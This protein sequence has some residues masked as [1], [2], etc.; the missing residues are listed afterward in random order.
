M[1]GF[2][3]YANLKDIKGNAIK[4][5]NNMIAHRGPDDAR[6]YSNS[7]VK[8]GFRRLSMLDLSHGGQPIYSQDRKKVLTFNGEIYNYKT[9]R[10][11]LKKKGYHFN[12][13]VDS[14]VIM[15]GYEAYGT[16]IFSKLNGMFAIALYDSTKHKVILARDYLGV[17]PLLYYQRGKD[18]MWASEIKAFLGNPAFKKE[19]NAK[20][21]PVHF[22]FDY[23][24]SR[25]TLFKNVYKVMPGQYIVHDFKTNQTKNHYFFRL[26][27]NH[28][29]NNMSV[30]HAVHTIRKLVRDSVQKH[31]VADVKGGSFLSSGIDSNYILSEASRKRPIHSFTLGYKNSKYSETKDASQ[32]AKRTHQQNTKIYMNADDFFSILPTVMYYEDSALSNAAQPQ[33]YILTKHA[34]N[35]VKFS[36][37]GEIPDEMCLGYQTQKDP[38]YFKKYKRAIPKWLRV[39]LKNIALRL[40]RFHGR[41]YLIRGGEPIWESYFRVNYLFDNYDRNKL[42]KGTD[43]KNFDAGKKY[44][45][46]VFDKVKDKDILTQE[47]YFETT[48]DLPM[49]MLEQADRMSMANSLELR[50][51]MDDKRLVEF[52]EKV[53]SRLCLHNGI[54]KYVWRKAASKDL[55]QKQ[56][57][58]PK[59]GFMSPLASWMKEPKYHKMIMKAFN[60]DIAHKF[61]NVKYLKKVVNQHDNGKSNMEKIFAVYCFILWYS[62]YFPED[63]NTN[64][65][66]YVHLSK[67]PLTKTK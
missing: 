34:R 10:K 37:T 7:D 8:I 52:F 54:N 66:K 13:D 51:P 19:F 14:E 64:Y 50:M 2:V 63:T 43:I 3:G 16:K 22:C 58:M 45:K 31:M 61:F 46:P 29:D 40:P 48:V 21:L 30:S 60:S 20:L 62:I 47:R 59:K 41:R 4:K 55:S 49:N 17:K 36:L 27:F 57:T 23:I 9:I 56:T 39:A 18:F 33:A 53:P 44:A 35:S 1:C 12:T 65:R 11:A 38:L 42:F 25:E 6:F 26:N 15:R 24:P 5:M 32:F 67:A 28:I